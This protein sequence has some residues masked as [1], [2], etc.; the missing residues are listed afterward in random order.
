MGTHL[1]RSFLVSVEAEKNGVTYTKPIE[2]AVWSSDPLIHHFAYLPL[3]EGHTRYIQ[4]FTPPADVTIV[5][6][7]LCQW[8]KKSPAQ[9][10]LTDLQLH[11]YD[12]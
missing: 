1:F 7:R 8:V 6:V 3:R 4:Q 2:N 10:F 9:V 5:A 12:G 11:L